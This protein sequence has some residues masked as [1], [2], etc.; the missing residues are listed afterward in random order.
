MTD[1]T[2]M[3][4]DDD[5][6]ILE[7]MAMALESCGYRVVAAQDGRRA[8]DLLLGGVRPALIILDLM[9]PEMDGWTLRAELR[10]VP[11][12][13]AIPIVILSGDSEGVRRADTLDVAAAFCKPIDLD[14]LV[15]AIERHRSTNGRR[16]DG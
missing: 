1:G 7:T 4:V 3:V 13:A 2:L 9:M 8:L 16:T 10:R 15:A 12:L 11:D 6:D 5:R 14:S